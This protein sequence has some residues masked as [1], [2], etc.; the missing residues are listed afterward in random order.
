M[1]MKIAVFLPNWIGDVVM[2]TPAFRALRER[3]PTAEIIG[4]C[5][6]YVADVVAGAPWFDRML[7]LDRQGP[8]S[9][10]WPNVAWNLRRERLDL[11][12]LFPNSIR[13][14]LVTWLA[15][16]RRI[17]GFNRYGRGWLLTE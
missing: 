13:S 4:V 3:Y 6:P 8:W 1:I 2:A 11:T 12:V 5:K 16:S 17:V 9:R 10:R 14:G 15:G 7:F